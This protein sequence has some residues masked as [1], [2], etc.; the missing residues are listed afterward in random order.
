[1][2]PASLFSSALTMT[3]TRIVVPP[4]VGPGVSTGN[5]WFYLGVERDTEKSTSG[6]GVGCGRW[7]VPTR[8]TRSRR[9]PGRPSPLPTATSSARSRR[10]WWSRCWTP[11]ASDRGS[12][13]WTWLRVPAMRPA[14]R[15]PVTRRWWEWTSPRRWSRQRASAIRRSSSGMAT[16]RLSRSRMARSMRWSATSSCITWATPSRP[17][18]NS[19][20]SSP[21]AA[22]LRSRPGTSRAGRA[23][24]ACSSMRWPRRARA[25]RATSPPARPSFASPRTRSSSGC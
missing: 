7:P 10:A 5:R 23:F 3:M 21:P 6:H 19:L 1:M 12:E 15:P 25:R 18:A 2:T 13:C 14:R 20:A 24:S 16:R 9:R 22:G 17:P 11:R 8:S 4:C